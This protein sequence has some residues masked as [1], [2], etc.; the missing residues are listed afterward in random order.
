MPPNA[1]PP[2]PG[3]APTL[4]DVVVTRTFAAPR[5]L[6]WRAWT[7]PGHMRRWWGPEGYSSPDC[8]TELRVGGRYHW[9]MRSPEGQDIWTTGVFREVVPEERLTYSNCFAD[10]EGNVV[11]ATHYGMPDDIPVEMLV[12]VTLAEEDGGTR[13]TMRHS[14][15]PLDM[16]ES[17]EGGWG[18]SF[19]K[20]ATWLASAS[21]MADREIVITRTVRAP[22][23]R[24]FTAFTDPRHV[25]HWWGPNGFTLTTHRMDV[26]PGGTWRFIM[27]GPDGTDWPNRI[28]YRS[29]VRP[30]RLEYVHGSD[31]DDDP[32]AFDV[33]IT[34]TEHDGMTTITMRSLFATA[35]A[36]DLK[37]TK[38]RAIEGGNQ[39]LRRLEEYLVSLA[40]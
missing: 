14:G 15:L 22:R 28:T 32:H 26:R 1:A 6:V 3:V 7:D 12:T 17:A 34:F 25:A 19:D 38:V 37:V 18:G 9:C 21:P 24:V 16:R 30:E 2:G 8:R 36:R 39:T 35:S 23:D 20:L 33:T 11:P 29:V 40:G 4:G 10:A 31:I 13:M 27:H 5:A